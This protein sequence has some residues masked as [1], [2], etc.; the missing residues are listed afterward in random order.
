[1]PISYKINPARQRVFTSVTGEVSALEVIGHFE[2]ARREG[3][4]AYSELID[5][6]SIVDPTLS[7]AELWNIAVT[8]RKLQSAGNFGSRAVWVGSDTNFVL[9]H[10][11]ASLISG[12]IRMKVFHDRIAAEEWLN[13]QNGR[14]SVPSDSC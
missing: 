7:I 11:F 14:N 9:A 8:V 4:L 1:M 3:F 13:K 10:M 12:F 6:S 5:A 2:T